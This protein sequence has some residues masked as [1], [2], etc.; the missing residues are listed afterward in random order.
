MTHINNFNDTTWT[1]YKKTHQ[2][3]D[4]VRIAA[5]FVHGITHTSKVDHSRNSSKVLAT[6]KKPQKKNK[7]KCLKQLLCMLNSIRYLQ[8]NT[9]GLERNFN[10]IR[11]SVL[12]INNFLNIFLLDLEVVTI[13]N[14]RLKKDSDRVWQLLCY[15]YKN[16]YCL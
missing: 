1:D 5:K 13:T 10:L 16:K 2:R 4:L 9:S 15:R 12:P 8:E 11:R 6:N 3:I 7:R 14:C